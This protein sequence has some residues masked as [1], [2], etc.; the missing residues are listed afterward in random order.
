MSVPDEA[1]GRAAAT[2]AETDGFLLCPE[3]AATLAACEQALDRG[4]IGREENVLLFNCATGL[5][6]PMRDSS[7]RFE[8]AI[9]AR[10][11]Q[12]AIAIPSIP[13]AP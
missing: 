2:A 7:E 9:E 12:G 1:L 13:I 5:K 6:Y 11:G 4:L 10:A 3:S 8:P